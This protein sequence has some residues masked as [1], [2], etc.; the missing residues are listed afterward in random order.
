LKFIPKTLF[1]SFFI[2]FII[3]S[4]NLES[5]NIINNY[6][7][8]DHSDDTIFSSTDIIYVN[9]YEKSHDPTYLF[10]EMKFKELKYIWRIER[11]VGW[12]YNETE[13]YSCFQI[14]NLNQPLWQLFSINT[15][16]ELNYIGGSIDQNRGIIEFKISKSMIGNPKQGE[17][18]KNTWA[19]SGFEPSQLIGGGLVLFKDSAPNQGFGKNYQ[20]TF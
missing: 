2:I 7:I 15:K 6:E 5:K 8:E 1:F 13:Y 19:L 17:N 10:I 4:F 20:I 3:T 18:L 14:W 11:T 16:P 12:L 9:F